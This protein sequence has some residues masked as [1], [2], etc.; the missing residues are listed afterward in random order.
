MAQNAN[1][2]KDRMYSA[3]HAHGSTA[4]K[5]NGD[6]KRVAIRRAR[7][8]ENHRL[9]ARAA[10]SS[11]LNETGRNSALLVEPF[12]MQGLRL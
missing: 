4:P 2:A 3:A 5:A 10:A 8:R 1:P 12:I 11:F 9:P 7:A 6:A